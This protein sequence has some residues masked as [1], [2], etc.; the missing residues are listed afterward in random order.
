MKNYNIKTLKEINREKSKQKTVQISAVNEEDEFTVNDIKNIVKS[1][2]KNTND[3][4]LVRGLVDNWKTL[5]P[6]DGDL[7]TD[8]E[9][10]DYL[11]NRVKT[12]SKFKS[13]SQVQITVVK[14]F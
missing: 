2:Q 5:K 13:F 14:T 1:L 11:K 6:M 7:M 12:T 10:D 8:G 3:K 4:V 9:I